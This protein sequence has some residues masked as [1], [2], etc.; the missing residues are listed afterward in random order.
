MRCFREGWT[1][2]VQDERRKSWGEVKFY[3]RNNSNYAGEFTTEQRH[4]FVLEPPLPPEPQPDMDAIRKAHEPKPDVLTTLAQREA[5]SGVEFG[6]ALLDE[7]MAEQKANARARALSI[8]ETATSAKR[9]LHFNDHRAPHEIQFALERDLMTLFDA[10]MKNDRLI[11]TASSKVVGS[12]NHFE[13]RFE[14]AMPNTNCYSLCVKTSWAD[15][16]AT[17]HDYYRHTAGTWFEHWTRDLQPAYPPEVDEGSSER[18]QKICAASLNAEA[19]LDSVP[20]IQQTI[21][22][23]MKRGARFSTSHK[24]GGTK[25]SW[26]GQRFV[27]SD[28][29][30]YP[31]HIIYASEEHFLEAL[32]KFYD[33]ETSQNAYPE[34]VSEL[35]A[36]RL[37]LRLIRG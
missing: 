12:W 11:M 18:Y 27:R 28:Y 8:T 17:H 24:E 2:A 29:G 13:L 35:V 20:A 15:A 3:A 4:F 9:L 31:D 5:G 21:V 33:W 22:A 34:K 30:D 26:D 32:R 36:W 10:T 37:M 23:A 14:A 19:H 1:K 6:R 16:A 25:I 7:R